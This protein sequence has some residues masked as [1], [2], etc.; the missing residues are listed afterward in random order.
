MADGSKES[1]VQSR[2]GDGDEIELLDGD[3]TKS[4][5]NGTLSINFS[6]RVN[7]LLI[8]D[9]ATTVVLKLFFGTFYWI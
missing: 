2:S 9:M 3:I 4:L 5:V 8:E 1:D 6:E 7:R